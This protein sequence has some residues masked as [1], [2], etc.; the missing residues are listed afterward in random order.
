[1]DYQPHEF[2]VFA[3]SSGTCIVHV[4]EEIHGYTNQQRLYHQH[5]VSTKMRVYIGSRETRKRV[6][7]RQ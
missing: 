6:I 1:M 4:A 2:R 7:H 3:N 5:F